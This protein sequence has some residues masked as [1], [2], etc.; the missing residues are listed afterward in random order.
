MPKDN[1]AFFHETLPDLLVQALER[2]PELR[3]DIIVVDEGQDFDFVWWLALD[4][5]LRPA[6]TS[7]LQPL[8]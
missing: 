3:W 6:V 1:P 8:R 4:S 7:R 5:A 2:C